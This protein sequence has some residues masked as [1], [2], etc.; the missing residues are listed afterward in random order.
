[1]EI[2]Q[3]AHATGFQFESFT[4][5]QIQTLSQGEYVFLSVRIDT[6]NFL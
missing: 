3:L 2:D 5:I 1:M 4:T 6:F